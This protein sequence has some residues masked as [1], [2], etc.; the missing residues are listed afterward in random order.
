MLARTTRYRSRVQTRT[1][2]RTYSDKPVPQKAPG[3][4]TVTSSN[5]YR[6]PAFSHM[7][8]AVPKQKSSAWGSLVSAVGRMIFPKQV[9]GP[10]ELMN[11]EPTVTE[12][13]AAFYADSE[14]LE[15]QQRAP[16]IELANLRVE[17]KNAQRAEL[18]KALAAKLNKT[19]EQVTEVEVAA[20][21]LARREEFVKSI[22]L[23][24]TVLFSARYKLDILK[25][26]AAEI[27]KLNP[28]K[29]R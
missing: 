27:K 14:K 17:A 15:Q 25:Q 12:A 11:Y 28:S 18:V 3:A 9:H 20:E 26:E 5:P 24:N 29:V 22:D 8:D 19:P 2:R 6:D 21:L 7:L 16:I 1:Q 4:P 13:E 23:E 10:E